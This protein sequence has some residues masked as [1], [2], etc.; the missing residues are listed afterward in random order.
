VYA[1]EA[2]AGSYATP[3]QRRATRYNVVNQLTDSIM[4]VVLIS[5]LA[6]Q[7]ACVVDFSALN[8]WSIGE[9]AALEA[10]L[11][12]SPLVEEWRGKSDEEPSVD[13]GFIRAH[14]I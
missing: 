4:A 6:P 8:V 7:D 12:R 10:T 2:Y 1:G 14:T 3:K 9:K 11:L 13:S 5:A